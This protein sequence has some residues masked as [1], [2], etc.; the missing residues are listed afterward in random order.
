[1]KRFFAG[2]KS[3]LCF[4]T[5]MC[6]LLWLLSH[7]GLQQWRRQSTWPCR[8]GWSRCDGGWGLLN[9]LHN[10]G[11]SYKKLL[12]PKISA[13]IAD[14]KI[15]VLRFKI[16]VNFVNTITNI[17]ESKMHANLVNPWKKTSQ[18]KQMVNFVNP[19]TIMLEFQNADQIRPGFPISVNFTN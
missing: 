7:H 3:H 10:R 16:G 13:N 2:Y 19:N 8:L 14:P 18:S 9:L 1:M 5:K 17:P 11:C 15:I 4:G 6:T 12:I